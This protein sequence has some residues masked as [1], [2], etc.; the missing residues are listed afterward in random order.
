MPITNIY[1]LPQ[2]LVNLFGKQ[3]YSKGEARLSVTE[4][5]GAPRISLLRHEH[6]HLIQEDIV[7]KF[8]AMMGTNVHRILEQ[9]ADGEHLT[10]E[11]LFTKVDDWTISGGIDLQKQ[12]DDGVHVIDWKFVS[13][14]SIKTPKPEWEKQLNCYAW[15]VREVKNVEVKKLQ[16]CAI[17]RDW[18]AS[19]KK[20][21]AAYPIAP[22]VMLDIPLWSHQEIGAFIHSRVA[23]HKDARR[24]LLW[25]EELPACSDEEMW[26]RPTT[27]A[28]YKRGNNRAARVFSNDA[29]AS[30]YASNVPGAGLL[31]VVVRPG[32]RVRCENNYCGVS[33]FCSQFASYR[34]S[35]PAV[36][37]EPSL[38]IL[39]G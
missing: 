38:P 35:L 25:G 34:D 5:I 12:T 30:S 1:N 31:H 39:E 32:A 19:R 22:V 29:E 10:E 17:L 2:P 18:A 14:M 36:V 20:S 15:L 7:D 11:R 26:V 21:D 13:V 23:A 27:Y 4:L 8:W 6:S 24:A 3:Q 28:V 9:G 37:S 33:S 16:V